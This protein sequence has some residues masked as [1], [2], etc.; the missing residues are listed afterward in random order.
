ML[1]DQIF[2]DFYFEFIR[3]ET[4]LNIDKEILL[5]YFKNKIRVGL[6]ILQKDKGDFDI[7]KKVKKYLRKV[8]NSQRVRYQTFDKAIV[9]VFR[10]R[11]SGVISSI[12]TSFRR[13]IFILMIKFVSILKEIVCYK[14]GKIDYLRKDCSLNIES[15]KTSKKVYQD[16]KVN[17][18]ISENKKIIEQ[19][20][21][22][23]SNFSFDLGKEQPLLKLREEN[24]RCAQRKLQMIAQYVRYLERLLFFFY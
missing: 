14:C 18:I 9:I 11:K 16:V 7:I 8:D 15:I 2:I 17:V 12:V 6:Q 24:I 21:M 19:N 20:N 4:I 10:A 23:D 13:T 3:L 5:R 22:D 1:N